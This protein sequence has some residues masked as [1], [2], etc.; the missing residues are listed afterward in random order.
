M[1]NVSVK[2]AVPVEGASPAV[3]I[4]PARPL[5]DIGE[6]RKVVENQ[7]P[8]DI[9]SITSKSGDGVPITKDVAR[10]WVDKMK[11]ENV[12]F[13]SAMPQSDAPGRSDAATDSR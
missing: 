8:E 4:R 5:T 10:A 3:R 6:G 12:R 11:R 7:R 9:V 1:S 2:G 13:I